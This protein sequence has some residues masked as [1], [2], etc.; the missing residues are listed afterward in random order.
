MAN[1]KTIFGI[2]QM[3][4]YNRASGKAYGT[5]EVME[6]STL[7]LD[8]ELIDLFGGSNSFAWTS[9]QGVNTSEI[10]VQFSEYPNWLLEILWAASVTEN[11]AEASGSI[12]GLANISGTSVVEAATGIDSIAVKTGKEANLKSST[13][14]IEATA[15]DEITVQMLNTADQNK[16]DS[17]TVNDELEIA[18]ATAIT[19]P[20]SGGTVDIDE[21]GWTITGG[22]GT[23][24][25]TIGDT[26]EVVVRAANS[27]SESIDV[28]G[29]GALYPEFGAIVVAQKSGTNEIISFNC[30]RVKAA[31]A[32][33]GMT[34]ATFSQA[35]VTMKLLYDVDKDKV[36]T[37]DRVRNS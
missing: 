3:T 14:I 28:G 9:E 34:R 26:A 17:V 7:S 33:V 22:T 21:L 36:F 25:M 15:V 32:P 18:E 8:T 20:D 35:D 12:N 37:M 2:H 27:G 16:G 5:L 24:A 19:I 29:K 23:V 4:F 31:G 1:K 6:G 13:Y 10:S 11:A 30:F